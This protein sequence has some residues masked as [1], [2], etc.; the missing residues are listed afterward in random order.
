[1]ELAR[2]AIEMFRKNAAMTVRN[3]KTNTSIEEAGAVGGTRRGLFAGA[4]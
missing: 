4:D 1:M 2:E 3:T